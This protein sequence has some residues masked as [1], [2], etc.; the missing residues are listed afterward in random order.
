MHTRNACTYTRP[1]TCSTRYCTVKHICSDLGD[2]SYITTAQ[3][4]AEVICTQAQ[5]MPTHD[6]V[7]CNRPSLVSSHPGQSFGLLVNATFAGCVEAKL[8]KTPLHFPSLMALRSI[9][10]VVLVEVRG[11]E[12]TVGRRRGH[13][14]ASAWRSLQH[15]RGSSGGCGLVQSRCGCGLRSML[16]SIAAT[17]PLLLWCVIDTVVAA[18]MYMYVHDC[19]RFVFETGW[20]SVAMPILLI[21]TVVAVYMYMTGWLSVTMPIL[22]LPPCR[23]LS[24][25]PPGGGAALLLS[26]HTLTPSALWTP[27]RG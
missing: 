8:V 21:D 17:Q 13:Q 2:L 14:S 20:L 12:E 1:C 6:S 19:G 25:A 27:V 16:C 15:Q 24:A 11:E 7:L 10:G 26:T 9:S 22:P 18:Y 23:C 3:Q 5:I 4:S